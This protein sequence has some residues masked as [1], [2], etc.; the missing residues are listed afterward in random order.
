VP[1]FK[2]GELVR[3]KGYSGGEGEYKN[4]GL[5]VE[6]LPALTPTHVLLPPPACRRPWAIVQW[7]QGSPWIPSVD[8]KD[9][10]RA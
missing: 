1:S 4:C 8:L 6:I 2:P 10:E 5:I 9:L 3:I 7:T